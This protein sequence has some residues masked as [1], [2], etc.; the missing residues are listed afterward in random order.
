VMLIGPAKAAA[1]SASKTAQET[2][3]I[4]FASMTYQCL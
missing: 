3:E 2:M 1:V 4:L